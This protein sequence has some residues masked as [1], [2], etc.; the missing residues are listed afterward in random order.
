MCSLEKEFL[1]FNFLVLATSFSKALIM[2]PY[3][4]RSSSY[5]SRSITFAL[6]TLV[7]PCDMK[8]YDVVDELVVAMSSGHDPS[9][10]PSS[11][12]VVALS[13]ASLEAHH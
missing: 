3:L 2:Q 4:S 6:D 11:V 8:Q 1:F 9:S 10:S 12:H 13:F 7:T 5:E